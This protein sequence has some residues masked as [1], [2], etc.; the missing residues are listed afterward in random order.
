M[1]GW[2]G[3]NPWRSSW[4][5]IQSKK[6][7][8]FG[9]LWVSRLQLFGLAGQALVAD[10]LLN[11]IEGLDLQQRLL[12][13]VRLRLHRVLKMAACVSPA[14]SVGQTGLLGIALVGGKAV[15]LQHRSWSLGQA[16]RGADVVMAARGVEREAHLVE[17]TVD[18]PEVAGIHLAVP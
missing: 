4:R 2:V 6:I 16:Q 14:L 18:R 5:S 15:G 3:V 17:L 10:L 12:D 1:N 9:L 7:S 11:G 13:A 8:S